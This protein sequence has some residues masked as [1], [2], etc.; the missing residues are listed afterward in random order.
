MTISLSDFNNLSEKDKKKTLDNLKKELGVGGLVKE[1]DI[2]R[3]KVYSMLHEFDIAV[4]ARKHK[5]KP[6]KPNKT[7]ASNE[8]QDK[9]DTDISSHAND[10]QTSGSSRMR[11]KPSDQ[12]ELDFALKDDAA[13][14]SL[15]L[16][17]QGTVC[18]INETVQLLLGSEQL[19]GSNLHVNI[20][21]QEI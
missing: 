12:S 18:F 6:Q 15:Y 20:S 4:S 19:E 17:T 1:W 3:S 5:L 11:K 8:T 13:K 10:R 16:E 9:T 2:S 21:L 7:L 14:F